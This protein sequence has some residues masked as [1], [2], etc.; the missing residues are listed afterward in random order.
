MNGDALIGSLAISAKSTSQSSAYA[1]TL[2]HHHHL[3]SVL[4]LR[5]IRQQCWAVGKFHLRRRDLGLRYQHLLTRPSC[6][7]AR[8][9]EPPSRR[10]A[11][12]APAKWVRRKN[13]QTKDLRHWTRSS[14]PETS[15][16]D[17]V[18]RFFCVRIETIKFPKL[19]KGVGRERKNATKR[20][21]SMIFGC[22]VLS[23]WWSF[24]DKN[25]FF[26]FGWDRLDFNDE[27]CSLRVNDT[28]FNNKDMS[29]FARPE[30]VV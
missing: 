20:S 30:S 7:W 27:L 26:A 22:G 4:I 9:R 12:A 24:S 29:M 17:R 19:N 3:T 14:T 16:A 25:E 1:I 13:R 11:F 21:R 28:K 10:Y 2:L 18:R 23:G 5:T 8:R 6:S 15:R